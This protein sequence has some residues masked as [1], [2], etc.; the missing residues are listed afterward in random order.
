MWKCENDVTRIKKY[1]GS[2]KEKGGEK[3][4]YDPIEV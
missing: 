2:Y 4:Q 3:K 1:Y